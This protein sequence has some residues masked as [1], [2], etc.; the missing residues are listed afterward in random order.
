MI[1]GSENWPQIIAEVC[2]IYG[3]TYAGLGRVLGMK[4]EGVRM[5][6]KGITK[7]PRYCV[8][9]QLL[10][11]LRSQQGEISEQSRSH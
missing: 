3:L 1:R 4:K 2:Q 9:K 5:I 11:M 6:S 7:E 8:G 10:F